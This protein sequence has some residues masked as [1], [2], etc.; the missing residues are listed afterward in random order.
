MTNFYHMARHE[1]GIRG[2]HTT[3]RNLPKEITQNKTKMPMKIT[4]T[5]EVVWEKCALDIVGPLSQTLDG[6][7]YVLTFQD[8]ISKYT[9]AIPIQQQEA[10]TL[11]KAFVEEVVLK[12]GIPQKI[13][14]DQGSNFMSEVF[15][16]V[17]KLLKI[18]K[19][20]CMAYHPQTN[21]A[22]ERTHRVLAEYLGSFILEDQS[23]G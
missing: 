6:N 11:A 15:I 23:N 4:T 12:F 3:V 22:L 5:P 8:E 7:K 10:A 9:L 20:K 14:T 17:C 2:V 13:L 21:G 19:T 18:K 16:N 1:A